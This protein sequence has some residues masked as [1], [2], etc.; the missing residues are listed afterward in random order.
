[1]LTPTNYLPATF[2]V[3]NTLL[4]TNK[5]LE[6]I[7]ALKARGEKT[8]SLR[9]D[10]SFSKPFFFLPGRAPSLCSLYSACYSPAWQESWPVP[11]YPANSRTP[12][13]PSQGT[14]DRAWNW[15][16]ENNFNYFKWRLFSWKIL[17]FS[18]KLS[19]FKWNNPNFPISNPA[20]ISFFKSKLNGKTSGTLRSKPKNH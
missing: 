5:L 17:G 11:T 9:L 6:C 12:H 13:F 1:M 14:L 15:R 10:G 19:K 4:V 16:P 7:Y 2:L 8:S 18:N 3:M 20:G